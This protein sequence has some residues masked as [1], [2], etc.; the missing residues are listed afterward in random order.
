VTKLSPY[1]PFGAA[2]T[3][4]EID[5]R[6][7][8][9]EEVPDRTFEGCSSLLKVLL[10]VTVLSLGERLFEG[11]KVKEFFIPERV[12]A[13]APTTFYSSLISD[14]TV[15]FRSKTFMVEDG[16]L[17]TFDQ[18]T[19]VYAPPGEPYDQILLA[20]AVTTI[21][22]YA[23]AAVRAPGLILPPSVVIAGTGAFEGASFQYLVFPNGLKRLGQGA[24]ANSRVE[25]LGIGNVNAPADSLTHATIKKVVY[26][27][28]G[29]A[30]AEL[31]S[32]L[33]G[34]VNADIVAVEGGVS[35]ICGKEV[36]TLTPA[37]LPWTN[38]P[39]N[40]DR[41]PL[42]RDEDDDDDEDL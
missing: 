24:L 5:C 14:L 10:P 23:F 28:E 37:E 33:G 15:S 42:P 32:A 29:P 22:D 18:K 3:L 16:L 12:S 40:V 19:V 6:F 20:D 34:L 7:T 2:K 31:C 4:T 41:T 21:Q 9:I 26:T 25:W 8:Q 27:G 30:G 38:A 17:Y 11:T 39:D 1:G 36:P 35:Q 13:I